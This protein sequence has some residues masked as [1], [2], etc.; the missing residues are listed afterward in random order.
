MSISKKLTHLFLFFL[1]A[2]PLFGIA[3]RVPTQSAN[4]ITPKQ[5]SSNITVFV[6]GMVCSFCAQG[7]EKSFKKN[8]AIQSVL[9]D[10]DSK[11][12]QLTQKTNQVI[13]DEAITSI[14]K[15]AG[16]N[17]KEIQRNETTD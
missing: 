4:A 16:Y 14:I 3:P 2:L 7:I 5:S 8:P 11:T 13:T 10:L 15:H 9:V 6:N 12:V 17:I 1:L